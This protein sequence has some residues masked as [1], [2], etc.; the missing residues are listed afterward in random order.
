MVNIGIIQELSIFNRIVEQ[1][2]TELITSS[3]ESSLQSIENK[4]NE[5]IDSRLTDIRSPNKKGH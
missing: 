4:A 5:I 3:I 1:D 2:M